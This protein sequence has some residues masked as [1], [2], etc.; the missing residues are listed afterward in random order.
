MAKTDRQFIR[1]N[2]RLDE[3]LKE[4]GLGEEVDS[5]VADMD[6]ADRQHATALAE[7][8][9]AARLTQSDLGAAMGVAQGKVSRIE[10]GE[11]M[12]LSTFTRYL[13]AVGEHP[14]VVVTIAGQDVELEL[15]P[16]H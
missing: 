7:L 5:I 15:T 12:L 4:P 10:H 8:R 11:D 14:R 6:A 16:N 2:D 3:A 1:I 13:A 9:R